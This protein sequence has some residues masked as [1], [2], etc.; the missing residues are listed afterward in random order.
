MCTSMEHLASGEKGNQFGIVKK[1]TSYK[2]RE[3]IFV[4]ETNQPTTPLLPTM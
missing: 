3:P 4:L 2:K 1:N